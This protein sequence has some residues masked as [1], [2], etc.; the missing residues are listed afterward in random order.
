MAEDCPPDA[1]AEDFDITT[2]QAPRQETDDEGNVTTVMET[3]R[4][5]ILNVVRY[6]QRKTAEA[7]T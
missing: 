1:I 3:K 2:Y 5:A 4:R 6:N 7:Q